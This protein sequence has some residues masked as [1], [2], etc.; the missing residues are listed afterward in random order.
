MPKPVQSIAGKSAEEILELGYSDWVI[1][2]HTSLSK[3]EAFELRVSK[4]YPN[5]G[6]PSKRRTVYDYSL[7]DK[8]LLDDVSNYELKTNY[9]FTSETIRK[10][11]R[12]LG[13]P[14]VYRID[15]EL[16]GEMISNKMPVSVICEK[17]N[18]SKV[19]VHHEIRRL[20]FYK[21]FPKEKISDCVD[22]YSILDQLIKDG[23]STGEIYNEFNYFH[24]TIQKRRAYLNHQKK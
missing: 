10:A 19:T 24:S 22:D 5:N 15:Y 1:S 9:H 2:D 3:E 7:L 23:F 17:L 12:R 18:C 11:R 4:G 13:V 20:G 8:L 16:M 6:Q 14:T 21:Q